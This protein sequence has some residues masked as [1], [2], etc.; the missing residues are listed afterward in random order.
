MGAGRTP[1][2]PLDT[3]AR[4]T[5]WLADS[6]TLAL[7]FLADAFLASSG[8]K[9]VYPVAVENSGDETLASIDLMLKSSEKSLHSTLITLELSSTVT[10]TEFL[11]SLD[12]FEFVSKSLLPLVIETSVFKLHLEVEG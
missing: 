9:I 5:D 1:D 11:S 6:I 8:I 3:T 10:A 12:V 4:W 2:T 7:K